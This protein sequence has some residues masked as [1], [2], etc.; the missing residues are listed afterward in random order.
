MATADEEAGGKWGVDWLF[1]HHPDWM[2]A[3][4]VINEGGGVGLAMGQKNV[5]TCQTAGEGPLLVEA[6]LSRKAG[7]RVDS[8]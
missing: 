5:Y 6:D 4:Y 1:E 2:K 7:A 8:P 3:E